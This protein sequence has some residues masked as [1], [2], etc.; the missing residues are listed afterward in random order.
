MKPHV[1]VVEDSRA[2]AAFIEDALLPAGCRITL[3][4]DGEQGLI[5]AR[6]QPPDLILSDLIM[7]NKDGDQMLAELRRDPMLSVVPVIFLTSSDDRA[8]RERLLSA[9][10]QDYVL[11]PCSPAELCARV[12]N[13]LSQ[14]AARDTLQ[15]ALQ[16]TSADLAALSTALAVA[17]QQAEQASLAKSAFLGSIS[18][19][20]LTPLATI[21]LQLAQLSTVSLAKDARLG[22]ERIDR[23][24]QRLVDLVESVVGFVELESGRLSLQKESLDPAAITRQVM[25][26]LR[27]RAD[28]KQLALVLEAREALPSLSTDRRLLELTLRHLIDNAIKFTTHGE[29]RV[30]LRGDDA[31][32]SFR[33][34]DTGA[35]IPHEQQ[36]SIFEPFSRGEDAAHKHEAG[37]GLGL[38]LVERVATAI[39][40][41]LHVETTAGAGSTFTLE[42]VT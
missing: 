5:A 1:L 18:H 14:K 12:Q 23:S 38:A 21:R 36:S 20:F 33:V 3:A 42:L 8:T 34:S 19:D 25:D 39:G 30:S 40:G 26:A 13:W 41:K 9:G 28:R 35:G 4:G 16:T 27:P 10:A 6:A 7:P 37:L 31:C 22:L 11:K 2:L 17:C 24:T 15:H 29:V 32:V